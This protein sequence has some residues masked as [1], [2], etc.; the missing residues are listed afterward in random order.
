M[1]LAD[2]INNALTRG[3]N[4]GT[5]AANVTDKFAKL[6]TAFGGDKVTRNPE[7]SAP[8]PDV[9]IKSL[10]SFISE[11]K[12]VGLARK[13]HFSVIVTPPTRIQSDYASDWKKLNLLCSSV[14]IPGQNIDTTPIRTFGEAFQM[15]N[16]KTFG[17]LNTTF[18]VDSNLHVK[19]MFDNW[20]DH[21][22]NSMSRK[23]NFY[24][25]YV[26][27]TM[28]IN[29]F[30]IAN[31]QHCS[32]EVESA[33]PKS[34]GDIQL[35]QDSREVMMLD[36]M[37]SYRIVRTKYLDANVKDNK[38][39]IGKEKELSMHDKILGYVGN[40]KDYQDRFNNASGDIQRAKDLSRAG[41]IGGLV[42]QNFG[43]GVFGDSIF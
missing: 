29:V 35:S 18:Y 37:W 7:K 14:S 5:L 2:Q 36:I 11:I 32:V 10:N 30:D 6:S 3:T 31:N 4:A 16:D 38:A 42:G 19:R 12:N 9:G 20:F 17:A 22:Q 15:P 43:G 27:K 25:D 24:D 1:A 28:F 34:M 13:N 21:I 8:E 33:F 26:Q 41:D 39:T 23:H 40:F